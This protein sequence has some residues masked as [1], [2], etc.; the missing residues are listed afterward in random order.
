[1]AADPLNLIKMEIYARAVHDDKGQFMH[2]KALKTLLCKQTR[3]VNLKF[4]IEGEEEV[5]LPTAAFNMV[6]S[7]IKE[8]LMLF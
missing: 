8:L 4:I 5:G 7:S 2:V 1:M 6:G 3:S